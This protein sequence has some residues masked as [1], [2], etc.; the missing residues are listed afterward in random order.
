VR[1]SVR[2]SVRVSVKLGLYPI[3]LKYC[4]EK[5]L[6]IYAHLMVQK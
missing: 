3:L 2:I 6:T 5:M 4:P 1:I